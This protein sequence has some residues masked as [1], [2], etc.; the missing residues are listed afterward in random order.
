MAIKGKR[1]FTIY[2]NEDRYRLVKASLDPTYGAGGMSAFLD[3]CLEAAVD[4]IEA[5]YWDGLDIPAMELLD[6]VTGRAR[7]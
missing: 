2:L 5:G 7:E 3:G 4:A 1:Q 6:K